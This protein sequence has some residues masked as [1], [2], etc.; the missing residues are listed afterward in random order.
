[1]LLENLGIGEILK[2]KN[3]NANVSE[4]VPPELEILSI[5]ENQADGRSFGYNYTNA[6]N[7]TLSKYNKYCSFAFKYNH[8]RKRN[9]RKKS[10]PLYTV[11]AE[12]TITGC[13]V[14]AAIKTFDKCDTLN[15]AFEGILHLIGECKA[16]RRID[17]EKEDLDL[18]LGDNPNR[19]TLYLYNKNMENIDGDSFGAG[20][21][22]GAGVTPN[23]IHVAAS[24][25]RKRHN[26]MDGIIN[27]VLRIQSQLEED[28]RLN[29]GKN[30][31]K[32]FGYVHYP[33]ISGSGIQ[34]T[35]TDEVLIRLYHL[36][37]PYSPL[38]FD[39]TGPVIRAIPWLKNKNG[40][41]K[42]TL[43][44]SLVIAYPC[45]NVPPI[46]LVDYI[47]SEHHIFS[48]MQPFLRLKELEQ[49]IYVSGSWN[50]S[51][52]MIVTDYSAAMIQAVVQEMTGYTLQSY[53][54]KTS[55]LIQGGNEDNSIN[56]FVHICSFHF[57]KLNRENLKKL[58]TAQEHKK[59]IHFCQRVLGS[60]ICCHLLKDSTPMS[61]HFATVV[62]ARIHNEVVE[63]SLK[64]LERSI[65]E[66]KEVEKHLERFEDTTLNEGNIT[67]LPSCKGWNMFWEEKR[68]KYMTNYASVSENNTVDAN[69]FF[70]PAYFTYLLKYLPRI[71]LWSNILEKHL[72]Q[73]M[74][75]KKC[76]LDR[77][78]NANV[79]LYFKLK[80]ENK[81]DINLSV[82]KF[83]LK[84]HESRKSNQR[85]FVQNF[86]KKS[87]KIQNEK[88]SFLKEI[89]V[90]CHLFL[91][92]KMLHVKM[93]K[94]RKIK[95]LKQ[96]Q[97]KKC[98]VLCKRIGKSNVFYMI[99]LI[100]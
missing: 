3:V 24:R 92:K 17:K 53:L 31:R 88:T 38:Y 91:L 56:T 98:Q 82:G 7:K 19:K 32:V 59:K 70:M 85:R 80:K 84:S 27:D 96:I 14:T 63:N 10:A 9:S 97:Q 93:K 6:F 39:A 74:T 21:L 51:P 48:I 65:I 58:Y 55:D 94:L 34:I 50:I 95:Q 36:V 54:Q 26:T 81:D 5:D 22:T 30:S 100:N 18:E 62:T 57:L 20:N 66:F 2:V 86:V 4:P 61:E 8:V 60:L 43:L 64:Y 52:N 23:S 12:C 71:A 99:P 90:Y 40:N 49:K 46:A 28:D 73:K 75:S 11:K 1:M 69:V 35:L 44:Y 25:V 72:S 76:K 16:R 87:T 33:S 13:P 89:F 15:I 83:I 68:K 45:G 77:M 79:E 29:D 78:T 47:T 42:R 67:G 41:P 37:A